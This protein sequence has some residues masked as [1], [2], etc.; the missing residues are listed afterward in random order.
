MA[1][2]DT[3]HRGSIRGSEGSSA[4]AGG[5]LRRLGRLLRCVH[6][7]HTSHVTRHTSHVT[8]HTSHFT[9]HTSHVTRHTSHVTRHT[10]YFSCCSEDRVSWEVKRYRLEGTTLLEFSTFNTDEISREISL[11]GV[12][13]FKNVGAKVGLSAAAPCICLESLGLS[14]SNARVQLKKVRG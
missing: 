2:S 12:L 1:R 11:E 6:T 3:R 10:S 7:R 5:T 13:L 4:E 9:R 8:R 14:Q